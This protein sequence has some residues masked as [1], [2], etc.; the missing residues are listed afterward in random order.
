MKQLESLISSSTI[1]ESNR[2]IVLNQLSV[3]QDLQELDSILTNH[4]INA[5][6]FLNIID[7]QKESLLK[8]KNK[9][10]P[11]SSHEIFEESIS[12]N[13][14]RYSENI[15]TT[16]GECICLSNFNSAVASC[17]AALAISTLGAMA[18][19]LAGGPY[20]PFIMCVSVTVAVILHEDCMNQAQANFNICA[21]I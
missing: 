8:I 15:N 6:S 2:N 19:S 10:P 4:N 1:N 17:D 14:K 9:Y 12:W 18:T 20:A 5:T 21:G 13:V 7:L 16:T 3:V 11:F